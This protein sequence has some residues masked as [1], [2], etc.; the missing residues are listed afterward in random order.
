MQSAEKLIGFSLKKPKL[1]IAAMLLATL[2]TGA[3][4]SKAHV[5]T[6][7]ENMLAKNE[8]VRVFYEQTKK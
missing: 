4:I 7:P 5:D 2:V 3:F 6:D 8:Q 1:V